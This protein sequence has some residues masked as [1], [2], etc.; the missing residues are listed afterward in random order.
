MAVSQSKNYVRIE[1]SNKDGIVFVETTDGDRFF[2][3]HEDAARACSN[4]QLSKDSDKLNIFLTDALEACRIRKRDDEQLKKFQL[5]L[6][7]LGTWLF[8]HNE[9]IHKTFLT[10]CEGGL[11]LVIV[12][13][14]LKYDEE[15]ESQVTDLDMDI[16]KDPDF[17]EIP[18]SVQTLPR[19]DADGYESFCNFVWTLEYMTRNAKR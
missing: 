12:R 2:M 3:S 15:F 11:L 1:A 13:K 5:L 18:F 7:K 4:Y 16:A 14:E 6:N 9:K 10:V 19:C 8:D 17:S